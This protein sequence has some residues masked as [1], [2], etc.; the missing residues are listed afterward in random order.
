MGGLLSQSIERNGQF[1]RQATAFVRE[2]ISLAARR[3]DG[4]GQGRPLAFCV[5]EGALETGDAD[6]GAFRASSRSTAAAS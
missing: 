3:L 5:G 2:R 6:E 4:L 1:A